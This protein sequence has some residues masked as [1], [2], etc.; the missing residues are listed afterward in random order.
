MLHA[1]VD[2]AEKVD[3][4]KFN[5]SSLNKCCKATSIKPVK[6]FSRLYKWFNNMEITSNIPCLDIADSNEYFLC[7]GQEC[8]D[9]YTKKRDVLLN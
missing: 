1:F 6:P 5:Q 9:Q 8:E 7:C 2:M 3:T 4:V